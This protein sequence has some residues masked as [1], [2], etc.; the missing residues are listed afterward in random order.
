MID[1]FGCT[2]CK[3]KEY[4]TYRGYGGLLFC[5]KCNPEYMDDY[6]PERL[7]PETP[8]GEAIV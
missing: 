8:K 6:Q 7:S 4:V 3:T 5:K 2:E 1:E